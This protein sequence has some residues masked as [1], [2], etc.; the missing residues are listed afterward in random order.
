[1][2]HCF[3]KGFGCLISILYR[4]N[5]LLILIF[6]SGI[7]CVRLTILN[8]LRFEKSEWFVCLAINE[9][10]MKRLRALGSVGIWILKLKP[11]QNIEENWGNEQFTQDGSSTKASATISFTHRFKQIWEELS[12]NETKGFWRNETDQMKI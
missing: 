7:S 10:E 11:L 2:L 12:A 8:I 5:R 9:D 6:R 1:M 4:Q 3:L